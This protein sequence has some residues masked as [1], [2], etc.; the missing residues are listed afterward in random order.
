VARTKPAEE[1]RADL[2]QAAESLF[3]RKG[4][5]A[6][7]LDEIT[8]AAGVSKGLFYVYFRS[9]EEIVAALQEQFSLAMIDRI[10]TAVAAQTDWGARLDAVVQA[11]FDVHEEMRDLHDALF[12]RAYPASRTPDASVAQRTHGLL[13]DTIGRLLREGNAAGAFAVDDPV[14]ETV[15]SFIVMFLFNREAYS[16]TIDDRDLIR[17]AQQLFRRAVGFGG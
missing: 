16:A 4:I 8:T 6:T 3:V 14:T 12:H 2:L 15:L 13:I 10:N 7:S 5:D 11:S 9:K 17:A 1:R